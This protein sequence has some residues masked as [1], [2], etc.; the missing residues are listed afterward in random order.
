MYVCC[1][2]GN[3]VQKITITKYKKYL[4]KSAIPDR[5]KFFVGFFYNIAKQYKFFFQSS[6]SLI[7]NCKNSKFGRIYGV[8]QGHLS[9]WWVMISS[10]ILL[11]IL[12]ELAGGGTVPVCVGIIY[13]LFF[14]SSLSYRCY[15]PHTLIELVSPLCLIFLMNY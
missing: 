5:H 1:H 14:S 4:T 6:L 8:T 13:I 15:Y 12:G 3:T 9:Y 10:S 7:R 11:G 2:C